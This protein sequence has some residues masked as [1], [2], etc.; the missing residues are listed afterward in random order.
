M[1]QR[2]CL[3]LG[4]LIV[5]R[6]GAWRGTEGRIRVALEAEQID[7]AQSQHVRVW[8]A[9]QHMARLAALGLDGVVLENEGTLL[10]RVALKTDGVLLCGRAHLMRPDGAVRVMTIRAVD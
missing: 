7:R 10:I 3:E 8:S 5:E 9:V 6:W 2:A 4:C 1:A